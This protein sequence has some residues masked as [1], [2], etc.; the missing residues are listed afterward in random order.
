MT[1]WLP[2]L[3]L[4][5]FFYWDSC[6]SRRSGTWWK[7]WNA[8][9]RPS[10]AGNPPSRVKPP[11]RVCLTRL[12]LRC[13]SRADVEADNRAKA[14]RLAQ[15]QQ[16]LDETAAKHAN[17]KVPTF[18][19]QSVLNITD[20]L[21]D[22]LVVCR[23]WAQAAAVQSAERAAQASAAVQVIHPFRVVAILCVSVPAHL[24][25]SLVALPADSVSD[26]SHCG[27]AAAGGAHAWLAAAAGCRNGRSGGPITH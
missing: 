26:G 10:K 17:D 24:S 27:A 1:P 21:L 6:R 22:C 15:L 12:V 19:P 8:R 20:R 9:S 4:I 14:V 16:Q 5:D 25:K 13:C 2:S 3:V 11:L 23:C 7:R 18:E